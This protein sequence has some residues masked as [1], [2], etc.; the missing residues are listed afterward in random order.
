MAVALLAAILA[1]VAAAARAAMRAFLMRVAAAPGLEGVG[2][3][4]AELRQPTKTKP[5]AR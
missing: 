4:L 3:L 5:S 1:A 2:A